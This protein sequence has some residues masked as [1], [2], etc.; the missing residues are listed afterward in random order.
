MGKWLRSIA[1]YHHAPSPSHS[2]TGWF[3]NEAVRLSKGDIIVQ[4]DDDDW[5]DGL[6]IFKQWETL[7]NQHEPSLTFTSRFFWYHLLEARGCLSRTWHQGG[8]SVGAMFAYHR[9]TWELAPFRDVP[10]GED[11]YFW[12]DHIARKTP[13]VDSRDPS[14]C[15]YVRHNRNGSPL[16]DS[17]TNKGAT[18]EVRGVLRATDDLDFYDE[19]TELMPLDPWN[20]LSPSRGVSPYGNTH[21]VVNLMNLRGKR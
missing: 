19:L 9:A 8:G 6:R 5:H 11:N 20:R 14:F 21:A 1:S 13:L 2:R 18:S 12:D 4:W 17:E 10:Q 7:L 15:V 3:H 16:I